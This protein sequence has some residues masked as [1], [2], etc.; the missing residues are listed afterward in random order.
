MPLA[1]DITAHW[2]QISQ[3]LDDLLQL[4]AEERTPYLKSLALEN[5]TAAVIVEQLLDVER[6]L[7]PD[8]MEA[9]PV[10]DMRF[11]P[12]AELHVGDLVGPY[13]LVDEVGRGGM[14]SVWLAEKSD[15]SLK[16]KVALKLPKTPWIEG[17]TRWLTAERDILCSLEH[18]NIARLY[19]AG[20]DTS[21]RPYIA[22]EFVE[23]SAIDG[24]CDAQQLTV[25]ERVQLF[26]QALAAVQYAHSRLVVHRDLK[27]ANIWVNSRG[28]VRLLDFGIAQLQDASQTNLDLFAAPDS[29]TINAFT[30]RYASPEQLR[31]QPLAVASD[32]YSL[33][34]TL[35]E[36]L[37]GHSPYG[38]SVDD[39]TLLRDA[40]MH[41]RV[42][43]PGQI[44]FSVA[45]AAKRK[46]TPYRLKRAMLGDLGVILDKALH[47]LPGDRYAS[48]E[49]FAAD[50]QRWLTLRPVHARPQS[51]WRLFVRF[52]QRNPWSVTTGAV[53]L[54]A[55]NALSV[56]ALM[57]AER[58]KAESLRATATKDF[59]LSIFDQANPELHG[60]R[61][62]TARELVSYGEKKLSGYFTTDFDIRSEVIT[63]MIGLMT[64]FGDI[65][66]ARRLSRERSLIYSNVRDQR[67]AFV[68]QLDEARLAAI[69]Q[70]YTYLGSLLKS[71][72][73]LQRGLDLNE[74]ELADVYWYEGWFLLKNNKYL[75]S[76]EKFKI[77]KKY[78]KNDISREISAIRGIANSLFRR[79]E[80]SVASANLYDAIKKINNSEMNSSEINFRKIEILS[81]IYFMGEYQGGWE[82]VRRFANS[83]ELSALSRSFDLTDFYMA[84]LDWC[85]KIGDVSQLSDWLKRND[86]SISGRRDEVALIE[87]RALMEQG[88]L[89][90]V[91]E[92]IGKQRNNRMS[93]AP[94]HWRD[95]LAEAE[96]ATAEKSKDDLL[97]LVRGRSWKEN[98]DRMGF[99]G[100]YYWGVSDAAQGEF[101][102][103]IEKFQLA[104]KRA[105]EVF[106]FSH[107]TVMEIR[108]SRLI[109]E[110][111]AGAIDR[112]GEAL[113]EI[114]STLERAYGPSSWRA[115]KVDSFYGSNETTSSDADMGAL[116]WDLYDPRI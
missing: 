26:L 65:E 89:E 8:F 27:P 5:P 34:V 71:M 17:L 28:E 76:E 29:A 100:Y 116:F 4:S 25:R 55:I 99:Y 101:R 46:T 98:I 9:G 74:N 95:L 83:V 91:K 6:A 78:A 111:A 112:S 21:S 16:R 1:E 49:A 109:A 113:N 18:P 41:G 94:D 19:D 93:I 103:A 51:I 61:D 30:V 43:S 73:N 53:S 60:G 115:K 70:D 86:R 106:G 20:V 38:T 42:Q 87:L 35:Y 39:R 10:L 105:I 82:L 48:A 84:W 14:G 92:I 3:H 67:S 22:M 11:E 12:L 56:I 63:S 104:E 90:S 96:L 80:A 23:G 72:K 59:L 32:I 47:I 62:I 58:A 45:T 31:K 110:R 75:E 107:P 33:G 37:T 77:S 50:L 97:S 102:S 52:V 24:Y 15:G 44:A 108:L 2:A 64:R 36:L 57:N 68:S 88:D 79:G 66:G 13:R 7:P 114:R 85:I 69:Q 40:V 54:V 81:D